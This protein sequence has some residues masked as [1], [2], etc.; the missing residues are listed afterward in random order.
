MMSLVLDLVGHLAALR[1]Q[2]RRGVVRCRGLRKSCVDPA[3]QNGPFQMVRRIV[4]RSKGLLLLE[5]YHLSG[6]DW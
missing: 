1:Y 6:T 2:S 3:T 4:E 5:M